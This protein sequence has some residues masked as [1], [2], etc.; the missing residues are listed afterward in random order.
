MSTTFALQDE[1]MTE[2]AV[3]DPA[4]ASEM[5]RDHNRRLGRLEAGQQA[6]MVKLA[7]ISAEGRTRGEH[8]DRRADRD[9]QETR[10]A[11]TDLR[12]EI[13]SVVAEATEPLAQQQQ[14]SIEQNAQIA[15]GLKLVR[16]ICVGIGG[17]VSALLGWQPLSLWLQ[18][19]LHLSVGP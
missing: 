15:G 18:H 5:I 3:L 14:T 13:R 17:I 11:I 9:A 7:E 16:N 4:E 10:Q 19:A 2:T 6:T 1:S 8:Q 12:A